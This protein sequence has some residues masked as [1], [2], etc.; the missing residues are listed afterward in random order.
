MN[1][2][3]PFADRNILRTLGFAIKALETRTCL[4]FG[5]NPLFVP[6]SH[7]IGFVVHHPFVIGRKDARNRDIVRARQTV[8][9]SSA[10]NRTQFILLGPHLVEQR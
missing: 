8:L 3:H 4:V 10:R 6:L 7:Y 5:G 9:A 2:G 1:D